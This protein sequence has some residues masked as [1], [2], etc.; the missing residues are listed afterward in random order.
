MRTGFER[1]A[2]EAGLDGKDG[3]SKGQAAP[4][5]SEKHKELILLLLI[6]AFQKCP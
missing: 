5:P 2:G 4:P 3:E 1:T 6:P